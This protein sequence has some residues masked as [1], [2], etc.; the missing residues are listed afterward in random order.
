HLP[1]RVNRTVESEVV[2]LFE[3]L[4]ERFGHIDVFVNGMNDTLVPDIEQSPEVLKH[5]LDVNLTGAFTCVREAAIS[6]RPG[7]VI[8]NLGSSFSL[9]PLAPG[10]AYSAYNA[11]I[12]MLTR[13]TVAELAPFGIRTA[14]VAP[15]HIRTCAA[16]GLAKVD[17]M[18]SASLRQRI[19]LGRVGDPEEVAEAAYFLASF[20]A[21][22]I[23]GSILHV[24]GGLISSR[25][26][27]WGSEVGGEISTERRTRRRPATRRRLLSP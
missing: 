27:A 9:S 11:G 2:S 26:A 6:M 17:G 15:G 21:S 22:Y 19:L 25:E 5:I 16:G 10:H 3:E 8:L 24:D 7:S 23:N 20:D 13:C 1:R 12:D 4:R 14:T 18:G